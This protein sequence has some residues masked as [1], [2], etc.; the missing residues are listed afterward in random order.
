M[1]VTFVAR[2]AWRRDAARCTWMGWVVTLATVYHVRHP[3]ARA[4]DERVWLF[5]SGVPQGPPENP[6]YPDPLDEYEPIF[7]L[8]RY[9]NQL[10]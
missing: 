5:D 2:E 7:D 9:K 8:Q 1:P 6:E 10:G 3:F 4:L